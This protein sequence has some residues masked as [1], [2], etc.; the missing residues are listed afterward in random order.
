MKIEEVLNNEFVVEIKDAFLTD[1]KDLV[2]KDK[3]GLHKYLKSNASI[4][5]SSK[6]LMD[7]VKEYTVS[8]LEEDEDE[9]FIKMVYVDSFDVLFLDWYSKILIDCLIEELGAEYDGESWTSKYKEI[10]D[11]TNYELI[12]DNWYSVDTDVRERLSDVL[13]EKMEE[14]ELEI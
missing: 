13:D 10:N 3:I 12:W 9:D 14:K 8:A 7:K 6:E 2:R 1:V 5:V 11:K 4:F